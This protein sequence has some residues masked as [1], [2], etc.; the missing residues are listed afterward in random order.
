MGTYATGDLVKTNGG[1]A[2]MVY[3][4]EIVAVS[5]KIKK[6]KTDYNK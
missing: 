4:H 2:A 5:E 3:T 6:I 1:A